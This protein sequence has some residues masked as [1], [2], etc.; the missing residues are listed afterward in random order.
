MLTL[1]R[2]TQNLN[3]RDTRTCGLLS[4]EKIATEGAVLKL[5]AN[6]LKFGNLLTQTLAA[7]ITEHQ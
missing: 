7:T 5:P 4:L 1:L 3:L 6:F 2:N